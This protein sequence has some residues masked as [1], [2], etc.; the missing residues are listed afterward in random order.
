MQSAGHGPA[1]LIFK[2]ATWVCKQYSYL[3]HLQ[4][5]Q[6]VSSVNATETYKVLCVG[7]KPYALP[8]LQQ[9]FLGR[10]K[11]KEGER[12]GVC[13]DQNEQLQIFLSFSRVSMRQ[14][15]LSTGS[16]VTYAKVI[17]GSGFV[18]AYVY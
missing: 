12:E 9:L 7:G 16:R 5:T 10:E 1:T 17:H 11:E 4:A 14:E 2:G 18:I 6:R 15:Y 8:G 13:K 3:T